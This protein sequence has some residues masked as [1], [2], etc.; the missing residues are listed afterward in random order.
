MRHNDSGTVMLQT[1]LNH[2]AGMDLR[3]IDGAGEE[4]FVGYQTMLVIEEEYSEY[5]TPSEASCRRSQSRTAVVEVKEAP[6]SR[7][8][9][10]SRVSARRIVRC[11]AGDI[12]PLS[13][14]RGYI[15]WLFLYVDPSGIDVLYSFTATT[16]SSC[17]D[18]NHD[19]IGKREVPVRKCRK[20]SSVTTSPSSSPDRYFPQRIPQGIQV[21]QFIRHGGM[22]SR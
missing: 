17:W 2:L 13:G 12:P 18:S 20:S 14:A 22:L 21:R 8:W 11:A 3:M 5:F 4:R 7:N 15:H 6:G 9:R 10:S 19:Q 16:N 1:G